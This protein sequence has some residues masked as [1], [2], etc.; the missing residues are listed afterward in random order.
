MEH[1]S[2]HTIKEGSKGP[3]VADFAVLRVINV[4][5]GLPGGEVWLVLRR[6]IATREV[7]FFLSN[8]PVETELTTLV[9]ISG[10]RW[11][12]E[13]CFEDGKQ[14]LGMGDYEVRSWIGWHHHMTLCILA[15]HFLVRVQQEFKK[16]SE[17][18]SAPGG[19]I[20]DG[21]PAQAKGGLPYGCRCA[22]V[23]NHP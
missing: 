21:S 23:P 8:A 18:D 4:R 10:M 9:R 17:A 20:V 19:A 5:D 11:P 14:F 12:I 22:R 1:W 16:N 15:H 13:T 6:N 3:I 7:K 2:R